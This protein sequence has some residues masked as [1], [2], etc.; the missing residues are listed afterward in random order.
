MTAVVDFEVVGFV[1]YRVWC[2]HVVGMLFL[3]IS[4]R[5]TVEGRPTRK[6][7]TFWVRLKPSLSVSTVEHRL[8]LSYRKDKIRVVPATEHTFLPAVFLLS[9]KHEPRV[10]GVMVPVEGR[11]GGV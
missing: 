8:L 1:I 7:D 6:T 4:E 2:G 3:C 11:H 5:R 9:Q 10:L